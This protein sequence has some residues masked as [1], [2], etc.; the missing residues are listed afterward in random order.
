[1]PESRTLALRSIPHPNLSEA[2]TE[3]LR[4]EN[5]HPPRKPNLEAP[6]PETPGQ[7]KR[8]ENIEQVNKEGH[9]KELTTIGNF[10]ELVQ[11]K[12]GR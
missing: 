12:E 7:K 2:V 4:L 3:A 9:Q 1:M 10:L 11:Q 5:K 8:R 6:K